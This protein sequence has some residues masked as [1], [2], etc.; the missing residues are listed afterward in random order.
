M[1]TNTE[2]RK[3]EAGQWFYA[4]HYVSEKNNTHT[5]CRVN[6]RKRKKN[7]YEIETISFKQP[8]EIDNLDHQTK[9]KCEKANLSWKESGGELCWRVYYPGFRYV[10]HPGSKF[11]KEVTQI[12]FVSPK[13]AQ[14]WETAKKSSKWYFKTVYFFGCF[15]DQ[16][17][18]VQQKHSSANPSLP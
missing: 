15:S 12:R 7:E 4:Q 6:H 14:E 5:L 2:F 8:W 16:K 17:K 1:K 9:M 10:C 18:C 11:Y 13:E 3:L